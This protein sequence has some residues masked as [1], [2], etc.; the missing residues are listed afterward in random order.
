MHAE[1]IRKFNQH[2]QR[3]TSQRRLI[4][5]VLAAADRPLI[6]QQLIKRAS[7]TKK[8]LA[9]SSLYRNLVVLESVGVVQRVFSTD[10]IVRYELNDEILGHHHHLVCSKCGEVLDVRIPEE[11]E[12]SLDAAL[13]QIAKRSG[14]KLDQHRLDLIGRCSKCS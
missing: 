13:L 4:V 6:I 3:Y 10:E 5:T 8:V 12:L 14:F 2:D 1:A 11:L 9:Q 7:S